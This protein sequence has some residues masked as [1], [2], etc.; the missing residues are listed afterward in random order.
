[1]V[2][3]N[4]KI[5]KFAVVAGVFQLATAFAAVPKD[6]RL[7]NISHTTVKVVGRL[8][9]HGVLVQLDG[10]PAILTNSHLV[11]DLKQV[12]VES[13]VLHMNFK[14]EV[15][16][17]AHWALEDVAILKPESSAAPQLEL[18]PFSRTINFCKPD[19]ESCPDGIQ[20]LSRLDFTIRG[21]VTT[22]ENA[23]FISVP[24]RTYGKEAAKSAFID[25]TIVSG[26]LSKILE[27]PV[28]AR[29]GMSGS[30]YF[31]EGTLEGIVAKVELGP[32]HHT[33]AIPVGEVARLLARDYFQTNVQFSQRVESGWSVGGGSLVVNY[34]NEHILKTAPSAGNTV[35]VGGQTGDSGGQTGDSGGG[36]TGGSGGGQTG[37]SGGGQTGDSGLREALFWNFPVK[38]S[39]VAQSVIWEQTTNPFRARPRRALIDGES[40]AFFRIFNPQTHQFEYPLVTLP[41]YIHLNETGRTRYSMA[42]T[43]SDSDFEMAGLRNSERRSPLV[44]RS[45]SRR[46][47]GKSQVFYNEFNTDAESLNSILN[48]VITPSRDLKSLSVQLPGVGAELKLQNSPSDAMLI[49][50]GRGV[51]AALIYS[52]SNLARLERVLVETADRLHEV[53]YCKIGTECVR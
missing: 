7:E 14:A 28:P 36:Q 38:R 2:C 20:V 51:R 16:P 1:M 13:P 39:R 35:S 26:L 11:Q 22:F 23:N 42:L 25:D 30:P 47:D 37:D 27:I 8:A 48:L 3:K 33:Y 44:W 45:Y 12:S 5:R 10:S 21:V 41:R 34:R 46:S 19:R 18:S 6:C 24:Q 15:V 9:G 40:Y 49:Y 29:E 4:R 43:G 32:G 50:S 52:E 17:H 53:V 31:S